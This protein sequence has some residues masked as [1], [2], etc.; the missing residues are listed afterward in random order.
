M[1]FCSRCFLNILHVSILL[2]I[3]LDSVENSS[4]TSVIILWCKLHRHADGTSKWEGE[5][6]F[7]ILQSNFSNGN[8][9][10]VNY[11]GTILSECLPKENRD[12]DGNLLLCPLIIIVDSLYFIL[13][14]VQTQRSHASNRKTNPISSL[15]I[16]YP[17]RFGSVT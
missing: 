3:N 17:G 10:I 15:L 2:K 5:G 9:F 8:F 4:D 12:T 16:C 1:N 13:F 11:E 7:N 14:H 6:E